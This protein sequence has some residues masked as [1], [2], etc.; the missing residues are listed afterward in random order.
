MHAQSAL[1]LEPCPERPIATPPQLLLEDKKKAFPRL[2]DRFATPTALFRT[3][4]SLV[5]FWLHFT[6]A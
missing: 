1:I 5:Q 2:T 3:E 6:E 4:S